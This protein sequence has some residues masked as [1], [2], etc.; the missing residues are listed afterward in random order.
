MTHE[1]SCS[2]LALGLATI[3]AVAVIPR[4]QSELTS[5][6]TNVVSSGSSDDVTIEIT[7]SSTRS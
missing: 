2:A 7:T 3:L 1:F 5:P 4:D 6:E